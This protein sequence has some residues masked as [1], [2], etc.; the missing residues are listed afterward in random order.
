MQNVDR[1]MRFE[2]EFYA[3]KWTR[4]EIKPKEMGSLQKLVL[5]HMFTFS[6]D[7][8]CMIKQQRIATGGMCKGIRPGNS[9]YP[10]CIW[11]DSQQQQHNSNNSWHA[12]SCLLRCNNVWCWIDARLL[13]FMGLYGNVVV[14]GSVMKW[15][16]LVFILPSVF[17]E[18]D[19]LS[20]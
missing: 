20:N 7:H 10:N 12:K 6:Y 4:D 8:V 15:A 5:R 1:C 2:S 3:G 14:I 19:S 18:H 9:N 11:D 17:A 13:I 16:K